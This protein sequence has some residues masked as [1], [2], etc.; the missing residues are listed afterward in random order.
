MKNF[1]EDF[2][3]SKEILIFRKFF[4]MRRGSV[5]SFK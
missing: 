1:G 2:G 3:F 4:L 5:I